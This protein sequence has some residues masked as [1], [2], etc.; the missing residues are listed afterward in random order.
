MTL[1]HALIAIALIACSPLSAGAL[2]P[3]VM[4]VQPINSQQTTEANYGP[5]ADYLSE[6]IGHPI[7][8]KPVSNY[9]SFW[10]MARR[11][12]QFDLALDAAHMTSYRVKTRGDRVIAKVESVVSYSFVTTEDSSVLDMEDLAGR[13][14][15]TLPSPGL[16]AIRLLN[17]YPNI[18]HQPVLVIAENAEEAIKKLRTGKVE[19]AVIPTPLVGQYD[20]LSV[21]DVTEQ[22]PAPAF[23]VSTRVPPR[24]AEALRD[25]LVNM[26]QDEQGKAVLRGARISGFEP[27]E[28]QDYAGYHVLLNGVWGYDP[29]VSDNR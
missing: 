26:G 16:G 18:S 5:M 17:M 7:V 20:G 29:M 25:A 2:E 6:H 19:A 1:R 27:A 24:V 22:V 21:V 14:V 10:G 3:L 11:E 4:V 15:A 28:N 23:T 12:K 8:L 9:L 13:R